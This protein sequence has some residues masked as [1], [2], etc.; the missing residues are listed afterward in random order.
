M[1]LKL[2]FVLLYRR[3]SLFAGLVF[4][5]EELV[6]KLAIRGLFP[7]LFAVFEEILVKIKHILTHYSNYS[8]PLLFAV[9]VFA[10]YLLNVTPAN[11]EGRLYWDLPAD[12][13]Y[14]HWRFFVDRKITTFS[15]MGEKNVQNH[16]IFILVHL[17]R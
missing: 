7:W 3:P 14:L 1:L 6:P 17:N 8:V 4:A 11:N 12:D 2:N 10:E 16:Q 15:I 9:L 13:M 5:V